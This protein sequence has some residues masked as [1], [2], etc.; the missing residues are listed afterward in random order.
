M[1]YRLEQ[2]SQNFAHSINRSAPRHPH[3]PGRQ[4]EKWAGLK[5]AGDL[6]NTWVKQR[7]ACKHWTIGTLGEGTKTPSIPHGLS[8][9]DQT[10]IG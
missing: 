10:A 9:V 2:M 3:T 7:F 4:N 6:P 5:C 8:H 1:G